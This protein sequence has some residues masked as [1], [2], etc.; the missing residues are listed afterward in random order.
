VPPPV[1]VKLTVLAVAPEQT[2]P[3]LL[4]DAVAVLTTT[5]VCAVDVQPLLVTVTV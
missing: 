2:G 4:A 1:A 3:S 5:V